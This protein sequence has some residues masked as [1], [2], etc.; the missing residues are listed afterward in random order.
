MDVT[1][2][3]QFLYAQKEKLDQAIADL[4]EL[5]QIPLTSTLALKS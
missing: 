4:E 3:I 2:I 5:G 1:K